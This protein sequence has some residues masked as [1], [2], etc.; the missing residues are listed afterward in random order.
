MAGLCVPTGQDKSRRGCALSL[1]LH[2]ASGRA[3][4]K[5]FLRYTPQAMDVLAARSLPGGSGQSIAIGHI[6]SLAPIFSAM[7]VRAIGTS[8]ASALSSSMHRRGTARQ[9]SSCPR[10]PKVSTPEPDRR[11]PF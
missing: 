11:A 9:D 5:I 4:W 1:S 3:S 2:G 6:A 8:P 7:E 10:A